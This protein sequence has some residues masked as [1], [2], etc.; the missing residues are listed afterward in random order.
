MSNVKA[1]TKKPKRDK[2]TWLAKK[3]LQNK[4]QNDDLSLGCHPRDNSH[5]TLR[6]KLLC[7]S[8]I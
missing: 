4:N 2:Y 6:S 7:L 5:V 8:I 1:N 3:Q